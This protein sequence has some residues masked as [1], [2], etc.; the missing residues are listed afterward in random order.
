MPYSDLD[1]AQ[2]PF[3]I[4]VIPAEYVREKFLKHESS[5][6]QKKLGLERFL[7]KT[8]LDPGIVEI[9]EKKIRGFKEIDRK[10]LYR[11]FKSTNRINY[12]LVFKN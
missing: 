6:I 9:V 5:N 4:H 11:N 2:L 8:K 7:V 10:S 1:P 3:S 12:A